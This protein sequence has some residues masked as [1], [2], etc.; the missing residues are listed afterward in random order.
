LPLIP[1]LMV[2]LRNAFRRSKRWAV[3]IKPPNQAIAK[4]MTT[5][6]GWKIS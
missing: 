6:C 1:F 4:I 5:S 2:E 3:M